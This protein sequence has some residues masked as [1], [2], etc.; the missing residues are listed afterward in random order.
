MSNTSA[1]TLS[2][3]ASE[4]PA[5]AADSAATS[6]PLPA[7][8]ASVNTTQC[9]ALCVSSAASAAP[10]R[11]FVQTPDTAR[12]VHYVAWYRAAAAH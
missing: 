11:L 7:Q 5:H 1:E 10:E 9:T 3:L 4:A 8:A 6:A 2:A 12:F